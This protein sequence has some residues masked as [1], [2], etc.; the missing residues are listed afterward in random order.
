[1]SDKSQLSDQV[2]SSTIYGL[3][4]DPPLARVG[5]SETEVRQSGKKALIG[6]RPMSRIGRA[7]EKG[8]TQGFIKI[9]VDAETQFIL[10]ASI[11]GMSGDEAIHCIADIMY[12]KKPYT[13]IQRAVHIHPT[14]AELIPTILG[15]LKPLD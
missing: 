7:R 14:V 2:E 12:A 13:V 10:G 15:E 3:F 1:M 11:L 5:M 9:L 4:I 8:E 6:T